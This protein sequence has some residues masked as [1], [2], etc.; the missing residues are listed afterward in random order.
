MHAATKHSHIES[1]LECRSFLPILPKFAVLNLPRQTAKSICR[2]IGNDKRQMEPLAII[3][4]VFKIMLC[5][6]FVVGVPQY[7]G[8][9]QV[10]ISLW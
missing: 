10:E 5:K 7:H 4:Y 6:Q 3:T 1:G 2:Q 9:C 8:L